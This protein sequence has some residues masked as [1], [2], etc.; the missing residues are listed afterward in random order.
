MEY[1]QQNAEEVSLTGFDVME[2]SG[3]C[4]KSAARVGGALTFM[5]YE[6]MRP[7]S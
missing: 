5:R 1:N 2:I 6:I 7:S 3:F 4:G